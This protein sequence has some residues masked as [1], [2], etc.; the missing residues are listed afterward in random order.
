[1]VLKDWVAAA[2]VTVEAEAGAEVAV[3]EADK[4]QTVEVTRTE[5][6]CLRLNYDANEL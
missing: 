3:E 4:S 5:H 6:T 2:K 1:M